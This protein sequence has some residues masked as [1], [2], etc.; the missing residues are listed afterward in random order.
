MRLGKRHRAC[1][2]FE[3]VS[4]ECVPT[5]LVPLERDELHPHVLHVLPR[6]DQ[7]GGRALR[8]VAREADLHAQRLERRDRAARVCLRA[9]AHCLHRKLCALGRLRRRDE[10]HLQRV[11]ALSGAGGAR[12]KQRLQLTKLPLQPR[13]RLS[14]EFVELPRQP[15]HLRAAAV[16]VAAVGPDRDLQ[17]DGRA[18]SRRRGSC[19]WAFANALER[20]NRSGRPPLDG[21]RGGRK[22]V[23]G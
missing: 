13:T 15:R 17:G 8:V 16:A 18:G 9:L 5:R 2:E 10:L 21:Y 4:E 12:A 1:S 23:D 7:L 19:G 6:L 11:L 20:S 3:L 14:F 22:R